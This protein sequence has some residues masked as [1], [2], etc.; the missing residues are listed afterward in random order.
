[1]AGE[2]RPIIVA[3]LLF[4]LFVVVIISGGIMLANVN[5]ANQSIGNDPTLVIYNNNINQTLQ[6][7]KIDIG[8]S[9]SALESSPL[10]LTGGNPFFDAI[11]GIWKTIKNAPI[12]IWNYTGQILI[13][14]LFGQQAGTILLGTLGAI[15]LVTILFGVYKLVSRGEGG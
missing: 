3:L 5:G 10:T 7:S 6:Q 4:G 15:L 8:N 13:S 12:T 2:F 9:S 14:K 11:G 1:M